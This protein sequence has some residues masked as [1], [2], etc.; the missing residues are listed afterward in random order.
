[1]RIPLAAAGI[2]SVMCLAIAPLNAGAAT[3]PAA[4]AGPVTTLDLELNDAPGSTVAVDSSGMGHN[5]AI[6]S[7][8]KMSGSFGTWDRHSPDAGIYYGAAHLIMVNDALDG[9][10]D[11][12]TGNFS[13]EIRYRSTNKFGNMIQ[14]GQAT[15]VGGQVKFQQPKGIMSCMFKS[16][17]T[18]KAAISSITPLN[19]GQW[20]IV[21]CDRYPTKVEMFVDGV[22]RNRINHTTGNIN[23]TK[24]WTIG[25]KFDC[26]TSD[27]TVGADSCDYWGGDI[28]YVKLTKG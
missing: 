8:I 28:D 22:F 24:P 25:G 6:G 21:R 12:G 15:T 23:N 17:S 9:S 5:G 3:A 13:V 7:H 27:P 4:L 2:A 16:S 18:S 14:K 20:H 10:L 1:M 26:D 11:P 19:D